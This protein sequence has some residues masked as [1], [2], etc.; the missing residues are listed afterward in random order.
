MYS[1]FPNNAIS[2]PREISRGSKLFRVVGM[3][4]VGR[5]RSLQSLNP[6]ISLTGDLLTNISNEGESTDNFLPREFELSMQSALDPYALAKIFIIYHQNGGDLEVFPV[7]GGGRGESM[8]S[9][10]SRSRRAT[11]NGATYPAGSV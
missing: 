3:Q 7:A 8:R 9:L 6:E 2:I 4:F 11:S 10:S 5:Q 1:R